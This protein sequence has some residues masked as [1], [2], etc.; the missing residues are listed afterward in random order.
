[1]DVGDAG[2]ARCGCGC[3]NTERNACF[4]NEPQVDGAL[5]TV[6]GKLSN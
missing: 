6:D 5:A 4:E 2:V 1:M 3:V